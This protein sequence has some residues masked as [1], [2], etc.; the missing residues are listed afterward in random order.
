MSKAQ[1]LRK[2][3]RATIC[4]FYE[5]TTRKAAFWKVT[6]ASGRK[7]LQRLVLIVLNEKIDPDER[8]RTSHLTA[9]LRYREF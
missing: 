5:F 4:G 1:S 6:R 7:V 3:A 8:T 2:W 9:G